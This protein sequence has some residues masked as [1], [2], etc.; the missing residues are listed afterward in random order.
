VL[1]ANAVRAVAEIRYN[2]YDRFKN[3]TCASHF[4]NSKFFSE[5]TQW[6][7]K[8]LESRGVADGT[9]LRGKGQSLLR[10]TRA[11]YAFLHVLSPVSFFF[12]PSRRRSGPEREKKT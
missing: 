4:L 5:N 3:C 7:I 1:L 12:S 10:I 11:H 6:L 9:T 8:P 2:H